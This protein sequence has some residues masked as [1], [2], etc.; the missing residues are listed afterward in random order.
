MLLSRRLQMLRRRAWSVLQ[1]LPGTA[2]QAARCYASGSQLV[3]PAAKSVRKPENAPANLWDTVKL[4]G[5]TFAT[6]EGSFWLAGQAR[7]QQW[8]WRSKGVLSQEFSSLYLPP[9]PPPP[10]GARNAHKRPHALA[11]TKHHGGA[12]TEHGEHTA[13]APWYPTSK[14]MRPAFAC[15]PSQV[16]INESADLSQEHHQEHL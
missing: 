8:S 3:P 14:K 7:Q 10:T 15:S 2:E 16:H 11:L 4:C 5:F 9:P 12:C 6:L 13:A 1:R